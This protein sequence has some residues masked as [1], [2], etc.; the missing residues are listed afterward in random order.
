MTKRISIL[1]STGSIG[2]N[3]LKVIDHLGDGFEVKYLTAARSSEVLIEQVRKFQPEAVAVVESIAAN[4]V[5]DALSG[6]GVEVL[7]GREGLLELA[8]RDDVD[9]VLNGLVGSAGM[10]PTIRALEAG[11]DVA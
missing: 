9:V 10:E 5:K 3:A 11:I 6:S 7:S 8:S 2:Q 1:G 4:E